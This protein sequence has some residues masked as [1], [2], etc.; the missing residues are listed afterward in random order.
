MRYLLA[1]VLCLAGQLLAAGPVHLH[2]EAPAFPNEEVTLYTRVDAF[3]RRL[4][5]L[6]KGRTD[7]AG[8]VHLTAEVEGT[9]HALLLVGQAGAE[10]WLRPGTYHAALGAPAP[11]QVLTLA[12]TARLPFTFIDLD[13]LD[14]NALVSDLNQRLDAFLAED[15]ATD[16]AGAMEAV[17]KAR[18]GGTTLERDTSGAAR[19]LFLSPTWEQSRVDSFTEKLRKFYAGVEDP[20]FRQDVEYGLAGLHLGPRTNDRELFNRFLKGKPVLYDVPEYTRF[21]ANFY[22]DFILGA[23]FR[24][25]AAQ[26]IRLVREARTDS[27]KT[28]L[29]SNDLLADAR[30][31]ELVLIINLYTNH[32]NALFDA[33]GIRRVLADVRD[34]STFPEHRLIAANM[35]WDLTAMAPG[36]TLPEVDLLGADGHALVTDSLLRGTTCL[37]VTTLNNPYCEQE[38][39]AMAQLGEEYRGHAKLLYVVLGRTPD[40][41]ARWLGG[42]PQP[43]TWAVPADRQELLDSWRIKHVPTFFLL[44]GRTLS[45]PAGMK[46][47]SGLGAQLHRLRT[48]REREGRIRPDGLGPPPKR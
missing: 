33:G 32:A 40:E 37:L 46:P 48:E 16:Q 4:A 28:L 17:A 10:L 18:S 26:L 31:N 13:P 3:T 44:D 12:G 14:V 39:L 36:S 27:L 5:P 8:R 20:W 2:V 42:K 19:G 45:G 35:L 47:S 11:G 29:A 22:G 30:I 7:S 15:L 23:P 38:M 34:R 43:G 1:L 41:L 9:R 6:A 25:H 24:N 21:F